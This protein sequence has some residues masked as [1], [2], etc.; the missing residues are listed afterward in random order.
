MMGLGVHW[1]GNPFENHW[2]SFVVLFRGTLSWLS[3][4]SS[5]SP[6]QLVFPGPSDKMTAISNTY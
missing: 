4:S 6:R 2:F 3:E 5:E 1:I